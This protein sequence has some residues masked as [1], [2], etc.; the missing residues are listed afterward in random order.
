M[1]AIASEIT[2]L[3]ALLKDFKVDVP[4]TMVFYDNQ[5][6][7]HLSTNPSFH[8]RSKHIEIDCHFIREKVNQGVIRLVHVPSQHRL[9]DLLTKPV[10]AAQ[11]QNLIGKLGILDIYF[12][13]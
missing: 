13:P 7:I 2:W 3:T 9:A 11:F 4:S 5:S 6:A 12:P 8:E 10:S 1:V